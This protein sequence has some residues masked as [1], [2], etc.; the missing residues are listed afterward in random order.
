MS[1]HKMKKTVRLAQAVLA[2][3]LFVSSLAQSAT[4]TPITSVYAEPAPNPQMTSSINGTI[5]VQAPGQFFATNTAPLIPPFVPTDGIQVNS[6]GATITL[7]SNV[8]PYTAILVTNTIG[9]VGSNGINILNGAGKFD[10]AIISIG[11]NATIDTKATK[12]AGI[13][14]NDTLAKITN[15][16]F[17][18]GGTSAIEIAAGGTTATI[19]NSGTG[20]L[21]QG[22]FFAAA[23]T[24]L[25]DGNVANGGS[26][27]SLTNSAGA[28]I[29]A[30]NANDAVSV[31]QNFT[32]ITNNSGSFIQALNGA[33]IN[34]GPQAVA[35]ISGDIQNYG[36]I[37]TSGG[38]QVISINGVYNGSITNNSGG[39]IQAT[40]NGGNVFFINNSFN[41]IN[42][43]AGG[44]IK[45]TGSDFGINYNG[46]TPG[47]FNNAGTIQTN[48]VSVL[49]NTGASTTVF[50]NTGLVTSTS[51]ANATILGRNNTTVNGRVVNGVGYGIVNTGTSTS[52]ATISNTGGAAAIDLQTDGPNINIPLYNSGIITGNVLLA[53]KGG[54]ALTM[55]GGTINGNVSSSSTSASTLNLNGGTVTGTTTLGNVNGNIV[56]LAGTSLQ[57]LNGGTGTDT[58]NL[59][60]GS[61]TALNGGAGD[62]IN[63][64]GT[65]TEPA[66][67]SI[68]NVP[69]INVQN[70][71]IFTVNGAITGANIAYNIN[72][73][74]VMYENANLNNPGATVT[75]AANGVL[76]VNSNKTFTVSN[77]TNNGGLS[78]LPGGVFNPTVSYT[79]NATGT[80]APVIQN[81][82]TYGVINTPLANFNANSF[83][84]PS[85]NTGGVFLAPGNFFDVVQ[86]GA[87]VTLPILV[88]PQSAL[89]FFTEQQAGN[90]LRVT[91]G[92]NPIAS[93]AQG[94]IPQ[95]VGAALDPLLFGGTTNPDL[96]ALLGQL[97][98]FT[99]VTTLDIALL[100]LVPSYNYSLPASARISMDNAFDSVQQRLEELNGL[101]PITQEENY[102]ESRD[103]ELYNGVNYGDVNVIG[104]GTGHYGA[105]VKL[106]GTVLDQHKRNQIEGF[107]A[108]STGI[109]VG[110]DWRLTPQA[111]VGGALSLSKVN[112]HD[113]TAQQNKVDLQ[114]YQATLYGWFEFMP[115]VYLDS[116]LAVA[117]EQYNT[118][119]NMQIGNLSATALGEFQG[120]HYGA[121]ADLGYAFLSSE[122]WFIAPYVRARYTYLNI[123]DYSEKE[124]GGLGLNVRNNALDE[125]VGGIGLRV[126][127]KRDFVTAVYVPEA[128]AT[129]LYDFAGTAQSMQAN[130]LGAVQPFYIDSVKP[131]QLIQLYGLGITAYTSDGYS[132]TVKGNFEY[133]NELFGYNGY[134]QMH[135]EWD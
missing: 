15:N 12:G 84:A 53:S 133:R 40:G 50:N 39:L 131:Q 120:I 89:V 56:N 74:G 83:L 8:T 72:T 78:I 102:N 9:G 52:S 27:L 26:G 76:Q 24:V 116:M 64:T 114:T 98:L 79:Q 36:T 104:F 57:A 49:F 117:S 62:V 31:N 96:L 77:A 109:S 35:A 87:P 48:A 61:F 73:G 4:T 43:N 60:G 59:S 97:E 38:G 112:T 99:D 126:A 71:G 134:L 14:V 103:Y 94:D 90:N 86:S 68:N 51:G 42:N 124:A 85:L 23:P 29:N 106:F 45:A 20:A 13:Y 1:G 6:T 11:Q 65:F 66:A 127:A 118:T 115:G 121:Q 67:S 34:I 75:I 2:S 69:I 82:T 55:A 125:M 37:Q 108:Q 63:V 3:T 129:L 58:F 113:N 18:F 107:L 93:V 41:T 17:I 132:F 32:T 28:I 80:Y 119:R 135:Y 54:I 19:S 25:V 81:A 88:Q 110:G 101:K 46:I 130:F 91:L 105:W 21:L 95:A 30:I 16:G 111:L 44:I 128:S 47:T 92:L 33:A 10:S 123:G 70:K 100:Q 122:N 22:G 5:E 7:D